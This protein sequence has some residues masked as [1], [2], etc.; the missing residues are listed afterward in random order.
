MIL[1]ADQQP[2]V[3]AS[4]RPIADFRRQTFVAVELPLD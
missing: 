4:Y 3:W 2:F 1:G